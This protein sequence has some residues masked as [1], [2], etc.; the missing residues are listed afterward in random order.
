MHLLN[1][2]LIFQ[3]DGPRKKLAKTDKFYEVQLKALS[4]ESGELLLKE[5]RSWVNFIK[6]NFL[7]FLVYIKMRLHWLNS[8]LSPPFNRPF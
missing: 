4:P 8:H 2:C 6:I 7:L 3:L 1:L 5:A